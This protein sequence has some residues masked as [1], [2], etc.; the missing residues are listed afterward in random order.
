MPDLEEAWT[1][2]QEQPGGAGKWLFTERGGLVG[3]QPGGSGR[4]AHLCLAVTW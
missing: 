4:P 3:V 2:A 1:A